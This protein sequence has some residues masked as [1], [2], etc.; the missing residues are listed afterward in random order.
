M[1]SLWTGSIGFGLV[2]IPVKLYS[3]TQESS[4]DLDMLDKKDK[5][6][7]R[8]KRV[9]EKTGREVPWDNIV[10]AYDYNG[11]Y[12]VLDEKDFASASAEKSKLLEITEFANEAD[13]NT[14]YFETPYYL[15]PQK[16][17]SKA[18]V[19]LRRAMEEAKMVG[20]CTFVLRNRDNLGI[21]RPEGDVLILEKMRF[22]EELKDYSEL[23]IPTKETVRPAELKM[24]VQLIKQGAGKFDIEAYKD[25]YTAKLLKVIH[26][27]AKGQKIVAPK[28]KVVHNTKSDIMDQLKAS[29]KLKKAS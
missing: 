18:Y 20:I 15:E 3:A 2:N 8:F 11:K 12:V 24:A 27:K 4:L 14:M 28:M 9:N 22:A 26:A 5:S 23:S 25:E 6:H 19:L 13:I 10:K 29:L 7:I 21:I 16:A 1:R 17:G